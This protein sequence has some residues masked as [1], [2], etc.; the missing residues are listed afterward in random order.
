MDGSPADLALTL[1]VRLRAAR[2]RSRQ[3]Q[4]DVSARSGVSTSTVSR[5]EL[6]HGSGVSLAT[7]EAVAAAVEADLFSRSPDERGVYPE[8]LAGLMVAG[9]WVM[10]ARRHESV[11]FERPARPA[12]GLRLRQLPSERAVVRLVRT[13]TDVDAEFRWLRQAVDAARVT[14]PAGLEVAGL[15]VAVRSTDAVRRSMPAG[16]RRSSERW[17]SALRAP[18]AT[19][20]RFAGW[21]WLAPTGTHLLPWGG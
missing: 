16:Q 12:P 1:G 2:L 21:V 8:A 6:G 17:L 10:T 15:I 5:M 13:V 7:W 19:M 9:G 4:A 11:W 18:G 20:P 14:A 3:T